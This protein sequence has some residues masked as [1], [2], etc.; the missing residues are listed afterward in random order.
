MIFAKGAEKL[1]GEKICLFKK[2]CGTIGYLYGGEKNLNLYHTR[3]TKINLKG[4]L[5][6]NIK[7]RLQ[8]L[9]K[10]TEENLHNLRVGKDVLDRTQK[11][12]SLKGEIDKSSLIKIKNCCSSKDTVF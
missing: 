6:L 8:N 11:A 1:N 12:Q 10:K 7:A 2:W 9:E 4:I 3:Y 5:G